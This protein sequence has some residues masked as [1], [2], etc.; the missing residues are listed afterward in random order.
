MHG[1]GSSFFSTLEAAAGMQVY[2]L[3][4]APLYVTDTHILEQVQ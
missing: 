4:G 3:A 2:A 1:R